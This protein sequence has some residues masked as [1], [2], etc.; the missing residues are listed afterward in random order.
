VDLTIRLGDILTMAGL[1]AGGIVVVIAL[2]S[3]IHLLAEQMKTHDMKIAALD[4]KVDGIT[5]ILA[6]IARHDERI[7]FVEQ[8]L[9]EMRRSREYNSA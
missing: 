6:D 5:S 7:R 4:S 1:F 9:R 8:E 3:S 2:R